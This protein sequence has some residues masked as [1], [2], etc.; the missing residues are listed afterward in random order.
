P[1]ALQKLAYGISELKNLRLRGLMTM[2][3]VVADREQARPYFKELR[4]LQENLNLFLTSS[5]RRSAPVLSMGM[6]QDFETA[7]EEGATLVRVG[8]ALF[9][10]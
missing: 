5:G 1:D 3:P 7:V 4:Q 9:E 2:A 6:S 10:S 8:T